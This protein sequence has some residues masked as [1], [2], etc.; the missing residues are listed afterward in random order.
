MIVVVSTLFVSVLFHCGG[1]KSVATLPMKTGIKM[2]PNIQIL[3]PSTN[4]QSTIGG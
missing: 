4:H 2:I 3:F 1:P